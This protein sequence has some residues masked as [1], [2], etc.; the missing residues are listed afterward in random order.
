MATTLGRI[1]ATATVSLA[2]NGGDP[3]VLAVADFEYAITVVGDEQTP[4]DVDSV[5]LKVKPDTAIARVDLAAALRQIADKIDPPTLTI[6]EVTGVDSGMVESRHL[7]LL[8]VSEEDAQTFAD[9]HDVGGRIRWFT[10]GAILVS[11]VGPQFAAVHYTPAALE[12]KEFEAALK[13]LAEI[14]RA[15]TEPAR[16][17]PLP[18][19]DGV[20]RIRRYDPDFF[21]RS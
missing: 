7:I 18:I 19:V 10:P 3:V 15:D 11:K 5:V 6:A 8:A 14:G 17:M 21:T 9:Y 12:S 13:R 20:Q 16:F 1:P 4:S 2:F